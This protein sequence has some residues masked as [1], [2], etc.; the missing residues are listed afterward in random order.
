MIDKNKQLKFIDGS[1]TEVTILKMGYEELEFGSKYVVHIKETIDGCNHILPSDGLI[2]K[3]QKLEVGEGDKIVIEKVGP[4]EKYQYGY[5]NAEMADNQPKKVEPKASQNPLH[6]E[7]DDK[8]K[9]N[10][11]WK[12]YQSETLEAGH[13]P[14]DENT[15]F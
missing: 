14:G 15:P 5:F 8:M 6:E 1:K 11:L 3:I 7:L 2:G 12:W 9:L 10:A 4:S 13:K